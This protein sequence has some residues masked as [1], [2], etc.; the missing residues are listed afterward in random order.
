[1]MAVILDSLILDSAMLVFPLK[2]THT[3]FFSAIL[4]SVSEFERKN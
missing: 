2:L 1:M 3:S 4:A